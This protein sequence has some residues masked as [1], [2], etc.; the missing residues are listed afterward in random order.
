M[1]SFGQWVV[2]TLHKFLLGTNFNWKSGL[3]GSY[4]IE[5]RLANK[6]DNLICL[7]EDFI[8]S[9]EQ[10]PIYE[11]GKPCPRPINMKRL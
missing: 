5:I 6:E 8:C 9:S 4:F 1:G 10:P 11:F 3:P 2:L 7:N